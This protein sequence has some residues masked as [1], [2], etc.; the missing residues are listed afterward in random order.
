[1]LSVVGALTLATSGCAFYL[2]VTQEPA[3][4]ATP[5]DPQV[6]GE[7]MVGSGSQSWV[8]DSGATQFSSGSGENLTINADGTFSDSTLVNLAAYLDGFFFLDEGVVATNG[9]QLTLAASRRSGLRRQAGQY[10]WNTGEPAAV[11]AARSYSWRVDPEG[12]YLCLTPLNNS[13]GEV[14]YGRQR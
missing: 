9:T 10:Q 7:W 3:R 13:N 4:P 8:D 1:L 14:C 11:P 12:G 6:V 5:P 2:P